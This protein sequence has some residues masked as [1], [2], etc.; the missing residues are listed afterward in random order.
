MLLVAAHWQTHPDLPAALRDDL[1][2]VCRN[3]E[4]EAR[5]LEDLL[6]VNRILYG[7]LSMRREVISVHQ[8]IS[9]ALATVCPPASRRSS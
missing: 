6:D 9:D 4:M 1:V 8:V 7:K 2:M 3:L 5:L